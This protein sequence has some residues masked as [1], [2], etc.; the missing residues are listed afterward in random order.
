MSDDPRLPLLRQINPAFAQAEALTERSRA[1]PDG[2]QK[3]LQEKLATQAP[4]PERPKIPLAL[5]KAT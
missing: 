1:D 5:V 3:R 2:T 4:K